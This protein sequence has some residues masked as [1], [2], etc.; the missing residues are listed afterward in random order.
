LAVIGFPAN[1]F[2][3]QEPGTEAEIKQFCTSKF[4][5]KFDMMSK[6]SVKDPDKAP[7]YKDLTSKEKNGDFGG[8]IG[9]NFTKFIV[10]KDGKV[11]ARFDSK[12]KPDDPKVTEVIEK[13]LAKK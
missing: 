13:E 4:D 12:T 11:V 6:V 9:W 7:L 1:D 3:H 10:G 5:V 8:E 2:G